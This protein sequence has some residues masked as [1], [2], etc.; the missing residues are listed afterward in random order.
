MRVFRF[1]LALLFLVLAFYETSGQHPVVWI[2]AF[3]AMA[4]LSVLAIFNIFI[5]PVL[6]TALLGF[7]AYMLFSSSALMQA[8]HEQDFGLALWH[9]TV[10]RYFAYAGL[11][12]LVCVYYLWQG[13]LSK[14][15]FNRLQ[16]GKPSA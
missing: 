16:N 7:L 11:C 9:N 1:F 6:T 8:L 2:L 14:S 3:G 5:R 4:L 15:A 13:T 10:T 12:F